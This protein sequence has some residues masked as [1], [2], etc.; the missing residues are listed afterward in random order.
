MAEAAA[1][2]AEAA[3]AETAGTGAG[4]ISGIGSSILAGF[5]NPFFL[6]TA[7]VSGVAGGI[8]AGTKAKQYCQQMSQTYNSMQDYFKSS[9]QLLAA[10]D[11]F[12]VELAKETAE[13]SYKAAQ[14]V[15][16]LKNMQKTFQIYYYVF[17]GVIF[18]FLFL[19]AISL[20]MKHFDLL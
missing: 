14:E 15:S 8:T 9:A 5:L 18:L 4:V 3:A 13:S 7:F 1:A 11:S 20:V 17:Q 19:A 16:K 10:M 2:V 12:D 6:F